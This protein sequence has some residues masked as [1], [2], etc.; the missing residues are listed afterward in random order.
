M[1]AESTDEGI[2]ITLAD[3]AFSTGFQLTGSGMYDSENDIFTGDTTVSGNWVCDRLKY[4]RTGETMAIDGSCNGQP[5]Q[6]QSVW[7]AFGQWQV[8]KQQHPLLTVTDAAAG[9]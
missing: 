3:C 7:P 4:I 9:P 8:W 5:T 6:F 2:A 1:Q